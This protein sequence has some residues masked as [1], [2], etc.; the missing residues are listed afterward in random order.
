V[1]VGFVFECWEETWGK[2]AFAFPLV[3]LDKSDI[4]KYI[5]KEPL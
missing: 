1:I 3:F 4:I 2:F 5:R